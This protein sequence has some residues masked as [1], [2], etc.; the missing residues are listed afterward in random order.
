MGTGSSARL[1][2]SLTDRDSDDKG[3]QHLGQLCDTPQKT[4][5]QQLC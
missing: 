4:F 3:L 1:H 2:Q 5:V